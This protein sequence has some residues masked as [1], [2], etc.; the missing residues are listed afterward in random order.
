MTS[1]LGED[2][3]QGT[4]LFGKCSPDGAVVPHVSSMLGEDHP[5]GTELV[6]ACLNETAE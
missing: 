1:I 4:A 5:Q 6:Y 2:D 3:P